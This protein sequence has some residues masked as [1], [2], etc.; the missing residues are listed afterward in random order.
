MSVRTRYRVRLI[1][2]GAAWCAWLLVSAIGGFES[3]GGWVFAGIAA[4]VL[5]DGIDRLEEGERW[6][7]VE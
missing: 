5:I 7:D 6:K 4:G 2:T 3:A 1:G